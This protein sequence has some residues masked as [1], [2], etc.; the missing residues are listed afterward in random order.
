[1]RKWVITA[2]IVFVLLGGAAGFVAYRI[3]SQQPRSLVKQLLR[4][5]GEPQQILMK[6]AVAREDA[7]GPIVDGVLNHQADPRMRVL[8]M[9]LLFR[10]YQNGQDPR[11]KQAL[12]QAVTDPA[13]EVRQKAV[14]FFGSYSDPT[15]Q[16]SVLPAIEDA[17]PQ[18]RL[19]A[20][21]VFTVSQADITK[22][23]ALEGVWEVMSDQQRDA[24]VSTCADR[25]KTEPTDEL[26]HAARSVVGR[27][28][29]L[30]CDR[31]MNAFQSGDMDGAERLF[32]QALALDPENQQ[33]QILYV[34]YL[35]ASGQTT[36][37]MQLAEQYGAVLHIAHLTAPPLIDGDPTD[38]VWQEA[39]AGERFLNTRPDRWA[40]RPAMGRTA[41]YAGHYE[42]KLYIAIL[43]YESNLEKLVAWHKG[44]DEDNYL[45]DCVSIHLNPTN[46]QTRET[47]YNFIINSVGALTDTHQHDRKYDFT[48]ECAAGRFPDRGYW[49]CE[50]AIA[51]S[52]LDGASI[53]P[54][55]LWGISINRNRVGC[56]REYVSWWPHFGESLNYPRHSL[57][58]FD[59]AEP[60]D[61]D[62]PPTPQ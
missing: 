53:S 34:R 9:Q 1:M 26:R 32:G 33:A 19:E 11:I 5:R 44:R 21:R 2:L 39:F 42:G 61:P 30:A 58:V 57:A 59:D 40:P 15:D 7:V 31:A 46:T 60:I 52:Q 25:M 47:D 48:S 24:L 17:D 29:E 41:L 49:A 16:L 55:S 3:A 45:D 6:L 8:L 12:L 62:N 28:V 36:R 4:G 14:L 37:A 35:L 22:A 51:V 43:G 56:G 20:Y 50:F 54:D 27:A 13:A 10:T 18:V 23:L 38:A